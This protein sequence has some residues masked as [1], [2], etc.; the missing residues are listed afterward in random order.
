MGAAKYPLDTIQSLESTKKLRESNMGKVEMV[1]DQKR[2]LKHSEDAK[3]NKTAR[4][5]LSDQ[6]INC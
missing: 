4:S 2:T 1:K 5:S 3:D 6:I